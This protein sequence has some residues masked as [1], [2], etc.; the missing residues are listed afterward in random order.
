MDASKIQRT[1]LSGKP[2]HPT[3]RVE[4]STPERRLVAAVLI[5]AG[6]LTAIPS[7]LWLAPGQPWRPHHA[8]L[9]VGLEVLAMCT[10]L[11]E[12]ALKKA[13]PVQ[14]DPLTP[15]LVLVLI[16]GGPLPAFIAWLLPALVSR[17][18][19]RRNRL[20]TPGFAANI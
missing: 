7:V 9:L 20:L 14:F 10:V 13:V 18:V 4:G 15:I 12:V 11:G 2:G 3:A 17:L 19:L 8:A 5:G 16:V 6:L 1:N